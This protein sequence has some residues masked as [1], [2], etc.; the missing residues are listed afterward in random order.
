MVGGRSLFYQHVE[1]CARMSRDEV[2]SE[3]F[4]C[5]LLNLDQN[6]EW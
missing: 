5:F 2:K 3:N 4:K 6:A 1:C